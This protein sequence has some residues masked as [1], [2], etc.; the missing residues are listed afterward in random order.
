VWRFFYSRHE[1]FGR[2]PAARIDT[3]TEGIMD[4]TT[5]FVL[6]LVGLFLGAMVGLQVYIHTGKP[7]DPEEDRTTSRG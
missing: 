6:V 7:K 3:G 4:A 2:T 5:I 1:P